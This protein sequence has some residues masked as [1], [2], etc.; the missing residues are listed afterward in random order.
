MK[1][2]GFCAALAEE[3]DS[4]R[5][6]LLRMWNYRDDR[7]M[8]DDD[9]IEAFTKIYEYN[10]LSV[11]KQ[12]KDPTPESDSNTYE[13]EFKAAKKATKKLVLDSKIN[14]SSN[15]ETMIYKFSNFCSSVNYQIEDEKLSA[16]ANGF[17][18]KVQAHL[19]KVLID[20]KHI[21]EE[22]ESWGDFN[23]A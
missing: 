5:E 21:H 12:Y 16:K 15:L 9:F 22:S 4:Y 13:K 3:K 1:A 19:F 2:A 7:V 20:I 8:N 17:L 23:I 6:N 14:G 11:Q 10:A 18:N